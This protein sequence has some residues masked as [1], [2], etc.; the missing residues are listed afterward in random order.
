MALY[1]SA[2]RYGDAKGMTGLVESDEKSSLKDV[3]HLLAAF[4]VTSLL[5]MVCNA[6]PGEMRRQQTR[7]IATVPGQ[8]PLRALPST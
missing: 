7:S 1:A 6:E 5:R 3:F 8:A 2:D 4:W